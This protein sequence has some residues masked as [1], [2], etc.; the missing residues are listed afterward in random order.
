MTERYFYKFF[1]IGLSV[2]VL[3]IARPDVIEHLFSSTK[4]SKP[5]TRRFLPT[6]TI[7]HLEAPIAIFEP[8]E[9]DGDFGV[10][11]YDLE[12]QCRI[13]NGDLVLSR[14]L[15]E[16]VYQQR[17]CQG[18]PLVTRSSV[19]VS[20]S[21]TCFR[22]PNGMFGRASGPFEAVGVMSGKPI[23]AT[24]CINFDEP[25]FAFAAQIHEAQINPLTISW[26]LQDAGTDFK[27]KLNSLNKPQQK[28][29]R[30]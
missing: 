3:A 21:D 5:T 8:D 15:V 28:T 13:S 10:T 16:L 29:T 11:V 14:S 2:A 7:N 22:L 4:R 17:D 18:I 19:E 23:A 25:R 1:G 9:T 24:A 26:L 30:Q 27:L 6:I 12:G 20:S